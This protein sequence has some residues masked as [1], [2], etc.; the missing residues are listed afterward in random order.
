[1]FFGTFD[2]PTRPRTIAS[3]QPA[4]LCVLDASPDEVLAELASDMV[5]A[6]VVAG[7]LVWSRS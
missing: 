7:E 2:Q 3:G 1:M 6:T 5:D 4:D